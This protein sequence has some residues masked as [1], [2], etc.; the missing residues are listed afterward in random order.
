MQ[1]L[2]AKTLPYFC[3]RT[4]FT[5]NANDD[6]MK[7]GKRNNN[8]ENYR[9]KNEDHPENEPFPDNR[10]PNKNN[11]NTSEDPVKKT[12][13][14]YSPLD[15]TPKREKTD[16]NKRNEQN[17]PKPVKSEITPS[18]TETKNLLKTQSSK[19]LLTDTQQGGKKRRE[20]PQAKDSP[21]KPN[22]KSAAPSQLR[23]KNKIEETPYYLHPGLRDSHVEKLQQINPAIPKP[24]SKPKGDFSASPSP[25]S[26]LTTANARKTEPTDSKAKK[27]DEFG[28]DKTNQ[29]AYNNGVSQ[30]PEINYP[31]E[32]GNDEIPK[33]SGNPNQSG[34]NE[35]SQRLDPNDESES[36][37]GS[38]YETSQQPRKSVKFGT[39]QK[40]P[41]IGKNSLLTPQKL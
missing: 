3:G 29:E 21:P 34:S 20:K 32:S 11:S 36:E 18:K 5:G 4:V 37:Q 30:E 16:N 24:K 41:P 40:Q 7:P 26:N 31:S 8:Y 35:T 1:K 33:K 39:R 10:Y 22:V 27:P 6:S 17:D 28:N 25:S 2:L 19:A 23:V 38:S 14:N 13:E 9:I 15:G 12:R